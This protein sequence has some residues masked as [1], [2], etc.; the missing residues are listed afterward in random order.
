MRL[1]EQNRAWLEGREQ[2]IAELGTR[3][4]LGAQP[5][6]GMKLAVTG[7]GPDLVDAAVRLFRADADGALVARSA[8][9]DELRSTLR[10]EGYVLVDASAGDATTEDEPPRGEA[11]RVS[12][13][14]SGSTGT[15]KLVPHTWSTL[16]TMPGVTPEPRRWLL[17]YQ[18]GTYAWF[19]LVTLAMFAPDQHLVVPGEEDPEAILE[20]GVRGGADAV[21]ATP[22]FWQYLLVKLGADALRALPARQITLGGEPVGQ[23]VLDTLR[24][25]F[26]GARVSHIY[27]SS[28]TGAAVVVHDG[29]EGFPAE[30]LR[31]STDDP[32]AS[33]SRPRLYVEDGELWVRSPYASSGPDGWVRTGD[34]VEIRDGRVV[35]VGR[36]GEDRLVVG[37]RKIS[38]HRVES[39]LAGHSAVRWCRVRTRSTPTGAVVAAEVVLDDAADRSSMDRERELTAYANDEGLPDWAVPRLWRFIPEVPIERNRKARR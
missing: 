16:F 24:S 5:D 14:T 26:P 7:S 38:R 6:E 29:R 11:G 37:G 39:V 10:T 32:G 13:V 8:L 20:A 21:S 28:E 35:V 18:P 31:S 25:L 1:R 22:T 12:V 15:P 27:A 23:R 19:Q 30:W 36:K 3:S 4:L 34:E 2:P 9:T 33:A 17:T